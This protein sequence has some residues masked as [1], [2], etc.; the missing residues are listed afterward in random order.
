MCKQHQ[1]HNSRHNNILYITSLYRLAWPDTAQC[2]RII[3]TCWMD[4]VSDIADESIKHKSKPNAYRNA[5]NL[6]L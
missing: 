4:G 1:E 2:V 6:Y 3:T 5:F